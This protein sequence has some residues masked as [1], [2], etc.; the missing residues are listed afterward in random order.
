MLGK[1]LSDFWLVSDKE[2][3]KKK[4][5]VFSQDSEKQIDLAV[6][7]R[8]SSVGNCMGEGLLGGVSMLSH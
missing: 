1:I 3:E 4:V 6:L 8:E 2:I 7:L 5:V